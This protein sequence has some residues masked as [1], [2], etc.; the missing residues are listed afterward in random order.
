MKKSVQLF[1]LLTIAVMSAS[2]FTACKKEGCMDANADNYNDEAKKDD[3][4]CTFPTINVSSGGKS[5]DI[6]GAGGTA[7]NTWTFT[8][9][10]ST[11]GWDMS[12][13]ATSGSF[14]LVLKDAGAVT[15][16]D[17]TLTA[18]SGAQDASGTS[19]SGTA[20]TWTATIT[21]TNFNGS[22][23]YSVL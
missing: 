10:N 19:S 18:G 16:L 12:I 6:K 7:S 11:T 4:N 14:R 21:L 22:G 2:T 5:G 9:N 20:G 23:D 1:A 13:G 15:V 3:G 8:N 17:K